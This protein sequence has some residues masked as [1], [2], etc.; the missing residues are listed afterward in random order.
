MSFTAIIATLKRYLF[1]IRVL[2]CDKN[3]NLLKHH[4][5][6][7][8]FIWLYLFY[9][10]VE[11]EKAIIT[12]ISCNWSSITHCCCFIVPSNSL[13]RSSSVLPNSAANCKSKQIWERKKKVIKFAKKIYWIFIRLQSSFIIYFL[14][15]IR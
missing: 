11:K 10:W 9:C 1:L 6:W 7:Y 2:D 13:F 8:R 4:Q 5:N 15:I 12:S 3:I 14:Y